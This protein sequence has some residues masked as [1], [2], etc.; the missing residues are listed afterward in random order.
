M[1]PRHDPSSPNEWEGRDGSRLLT[2]GGAEPIILSDNV[3][4]YDRPLSAEERMVYRLHCEERSKYVEDL[5]RDN[6][7][8]PNSV[9]RVEREI[10]EVDMKLALAKLTFVLWI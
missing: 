10:T 7:T 9:S 1:Q 5:M 2:P 8:K 3:E 6:K 4:V